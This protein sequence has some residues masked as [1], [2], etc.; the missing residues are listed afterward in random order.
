[1]QAFQKYA[2]DVGLVADGAG[3]DGF[4]LQG[5]ELNLLCD[6]ALAEVFEFLVVRWRG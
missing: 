2:V 5:F 6:E 1:M 4:L 3:L